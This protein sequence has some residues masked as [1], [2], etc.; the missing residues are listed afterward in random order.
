MK[1][2]LVIFYLVF[3]TVPWVFVGEGHLFVL[4]FMTER[5]E[6]FGW[7]K[8]LNFS[9]LVAMGVT[10]FLSLMLGMATLLSRDYCGGYCPTTFFNHVYRTFFSR[11]WLRS[12]LGMIVIVGLLVLFA[13]SFV[14]YGVGAEIIAHDMINVTVSTPLLMVIALSLL[15]L[16]QTVMLKG[17]YC[18]NLCPYQ[19]TTFIFYAKK[20]YRIGIVI[21]CVGILI[22]AYLAISDHLSYCL[23]E[24]K[25]LYIR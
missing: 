10:L 12:M 3:V 7:Q 21:L 20:Y 2:S 17:W 13:F 8:E 14:A 5:V 22:V 23:I 11:G 9:T 25:A 19:A 4:N 24:N 6:F 18:K 15:L 1:R 16:V